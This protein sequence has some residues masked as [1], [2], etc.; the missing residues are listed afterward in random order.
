VKEQLRQF[1]PLDDNSCAPMHERRKNNL[2]MPNLSNQSLCDLTPVKQKLVE[3]YESFDL[4]HQQKRKVG[5]LKQGSPDTKK[6]R[7]SPRLTCLKNT[8]ER[9][10]N[11]LKEISEVEPSPAM[12]NQV[13]DGADASCLL[14]EKQDSVLKGTHEEVIGKS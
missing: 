8:S 3:K 13:T 2:E 4:L 14:P 12:E 9:T 5:K 10:N 11:T 6:P 1:F 7:R